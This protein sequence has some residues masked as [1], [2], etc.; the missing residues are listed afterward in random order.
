MPYQTLR[1]YL[2]YTVVSSDNQIERKT[3]AVFE[4]VTKLS[5]SNNPEKVNRFHIL[6]YNIPIFANLLHLNKMFIEST[7]K[8]FFN[9]SGKQQEQ[10]TRR[11]HPTCAF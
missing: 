9:I 4:S 7:E 5:N 3:C 6:L 1:V 8:Y 10:N 2:Y 11:N